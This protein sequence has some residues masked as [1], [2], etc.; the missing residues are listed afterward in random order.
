MV[1]SQEM[2]QKRLLIIIAAIVV[3]AGLAAG[4]YFFLRPSERI[5]EWRN[6]AGQLHR[7]NDLPAQIYYDESGEISSELWYLNGKPD[8]ENGLPLIKHRY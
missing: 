3:I 4:A 8:R 1:Q 5:E 2:K 7:E 6:D